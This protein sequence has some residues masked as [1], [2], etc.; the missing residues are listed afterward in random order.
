[1]ISRALTPEELDAMV[2]TDFDLYGPYEPECWGI[3]S[4]EHH[5]GECK[6]FTDEYHAFAA[7][8]W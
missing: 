1:M 7:R 4:Y 8:E 5:K 2:P 6:H 3:N